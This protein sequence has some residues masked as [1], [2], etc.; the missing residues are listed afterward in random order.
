LTLIPHLGLLSKKAGLRSH[1][2]RKL[3]LKWRARTFAYNFTRK[4]VSFVGGNRGQRSSVLRETRPFVA[5]D[6]FRIWQTIQPNSSIHFSRC[7]S[8]CIT[9]ER[10]EDETKTNKKTKTR[11]GYLILV[12]AHHRSWYAGRLVHMHQC[13]EG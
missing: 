7:N 6:S 1:C 2:R 9:F 5:H 10:M 11:G 8:R 3:E 4:N 12:A 13:M